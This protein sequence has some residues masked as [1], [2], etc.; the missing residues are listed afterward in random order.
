MFVIA[1]NLFD[2]ACNNEN[3]FVALG[4]SNLHANDLIYHR[5]NIETSLTPS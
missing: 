5:P 2:R 1:S 4:L 3:K